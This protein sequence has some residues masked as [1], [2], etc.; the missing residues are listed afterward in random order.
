MR[1]LINRAFLSLA[2]KAGLTAAILDPL[3]SLLM[4]TLKATQVLLDQDPWCRVHTGISRG[5]LTS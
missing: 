3:D 2:L 5:R 4:G 1:P